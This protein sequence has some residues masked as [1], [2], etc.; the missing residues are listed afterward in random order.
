M[1][2]DD[3]EGGGPS[4]ELAEPLAH[5]CGRAHYEGGAKQ[6]GVVQA[7]QECRHLQQCEVGCAVRGVC[8]A[9]SPPLTKPMTRKAAGVLIGWNG[10]WECGK[11]LQWSLEPHGGPASSPLLHR[12][13]LESPLAHPPSLQRIE[14]ARRCTWLIE[15]QVL[16]GM[17]MLMC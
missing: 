4:S 9:V 1:Q 3:S 12:S 13:L 14:R 5:D 6:L 15:S 2:D 17:W 8:A 11:H 7:S 16:T 10:D